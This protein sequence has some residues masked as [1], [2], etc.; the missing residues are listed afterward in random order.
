MDKHKRFLD[1]GFM[2]AVPLMI[3]VQGLSGTHDLTLGECL[4]LI[5]LVFI[6]GNQGEK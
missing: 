4:I 6:L 5:G 3:I 2:L 1:I